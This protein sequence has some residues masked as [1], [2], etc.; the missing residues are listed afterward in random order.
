[1]AK[2]FTRIQVLKGID[3]GGGP[4]LSGKV[5]AEPNKRYRAVIFDLD[6]TL[7]DHFRVIY[8]CYEYALE[9]LS[10]E[11]VT[12][13][14]VRASVG[15]SIVI[16]FG[17]LIP[18]EHIEEA[19]LH[20]RDEF[21]RIWHED[22]GILPGAEWLLKNLHAQGLGLSVFTNKEGDRARRI[23]KHVR[24]EAHLDGIFGTLD[25]PWRKPQPEFTRHVLEQLGTDPAHACMVGDSPYD[26]EAAAV[27]GMPCYVVATGSHTVEEL[28]AQT[29]AAGIY[30]NLYELGEAVFHL[31]PPQ[32]APA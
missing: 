19:V 17:K 16:T 5:Q 32:S 4:F 23:L 22:I 12:Y 13:E 24:M 31:Q 15:G 3:N 18:E 29:N 28:K 9:K 7:I 27:A 2:D 30:R 1:M 20:F 14:K 6:G 25:T 26:V 11:P 10:L 21:D 8:R